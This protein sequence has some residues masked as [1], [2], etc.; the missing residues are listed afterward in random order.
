MA[1]RICWERR[2]MRSGSLSERVSVASVAL[3]ATTQTSPRV[4]YS[5]RSGVYLSPTI[6]FGMPF[7]RRSSIVR[8]DECNAVVQE[9]VE[10]GDGSIRHHVAENSDEAKVHYDLL[11]VR[12]SICGCS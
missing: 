11:C 4:G 9:L 12:I 2:G 7:S 5:F 10:T 1:Y 3:A 8:S 6:T